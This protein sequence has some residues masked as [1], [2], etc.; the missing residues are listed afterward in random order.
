MELTV[1]DERKLVEIWLTN[2]EKSDPVLRAGLQGIYDTYK[3]KKYLVAVFESGN[4]DLYAQTRDLLLYNRQRLAERHE[5]QQITVRLARKCQIVLFK[6]PFHM[7]SHCRM[8]QA[9]SQQAAFSGPGHFRQQF[10]ITDK[11]L[12]SQAAEKLTR[13]VPITQ[14]FD[15]LAV[16]RCRNIHR[17]RICIDKAEMLGGFAESK[18]CFG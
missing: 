7:R 2:A 6:H 15:V 16:F 10:H 12:T 18:S 13:I 5:T 11:I 8:L 1:K 4:C 9:E 17:Y 14:G 3:K